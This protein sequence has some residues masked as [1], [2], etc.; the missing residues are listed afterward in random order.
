MMVAE[1][2]SK[3]SAV[4][5]EVPAEIYHQHCGVLRASQKLGIIRMDV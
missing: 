5:G 2:S 3:I 1:I 4:T